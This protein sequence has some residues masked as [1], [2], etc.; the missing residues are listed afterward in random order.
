MPI[1]HA[2]AQLA[3]VP[4]TARRDVGGVA[5]IV[6]PLCCN[7]GEEPGDRRRSWDA[8]HADGRCGRWSALVAA[9][10]ELRA[11]PASRQANFQVYHAPEPLVE[12]WVPC[13]GPPGTVRRVMVDPETEPP[14]EEPEPETRPRRTV[15]FLRP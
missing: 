2:G 6:L 4:A 9:G 5:A 7:P 10:V 3:D 8:W 15:A 1:L 14:Q 11:L 12:K 13:D